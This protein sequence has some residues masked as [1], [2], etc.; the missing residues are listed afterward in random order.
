MDDACA[1]IESFASESACNAPEAL[2]VLL[3]LFSKKML[4]KLEHA[5][6]YQT[7]RPLALE[8]KYGTENEES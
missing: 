3:L 5:T 8:V 2:T 7:L 6:I 1:M 4:T